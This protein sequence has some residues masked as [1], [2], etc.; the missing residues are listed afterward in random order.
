MDDFERKNFGLKEEVLEYREKF[1]TDNF[2]KTSQ[3]IFVFLTC[4]IIWMSLRQ[5]TIVQFKDR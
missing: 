1:L 5:K 3:N 4:S 2:A